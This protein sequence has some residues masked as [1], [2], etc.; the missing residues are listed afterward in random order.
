MP[1]GPRRKISDALPHAAPCRA[2]LS[3]H[4]AID[5][6]NRETGA[7]IACKDAFQLSRDLPQSR[8]SPD[9]LERQFHQRRFLLQSSLIQG[10]ETPL[11]QS[12]ISLCP[13]IFQILDLL[14]ADAAGLDGQER[15]V[16]GLHRPPHAA[17]ACWLAVSGF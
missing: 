15:D 2:F 16:R 9:R 12:L 17:A 8:P 6:S 1:P 11:A 4:A 3:E 5:A 13:Q 14:V 7:L 10:L